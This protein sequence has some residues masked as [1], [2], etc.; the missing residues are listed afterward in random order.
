[1]EQRGTTLRMS[2]QIFLAMFDKDESKESSTLREILGVL[3]CLRA[4]ARSSK[5][6]I[7]FACDNTQTVF[8]IKFGS[9]TKQIQRIG[10]EIFEWCLKHNKIC[11]PVW[12]PRSHHLIKEAD[13]AKEP[14]DYTL[15][16]KSPIGS[17]RPRE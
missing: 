14:D 15:R 5:I 12:L 4:T 2:D 16:P 1:M 11:W 7:I 17:S 3:K 9:R 13:V 6:I 8:A 10:Q